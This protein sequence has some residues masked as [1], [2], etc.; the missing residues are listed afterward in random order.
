MSTQIFD[1]VELTTGIVFPKASGLGIKI[2]PFGPAAF[3][4]RDLTGQINPHVGGGATPPVSTLV[5]GTGTHVRAYAFPTNAVIDDITFHMPHDYVPGTDMYLHLHWT[6]AGTAIS[7][8]LV[9][10]WY[11]TY[12]KGYNQASQT[13][14]AE[15]NV[16]L[17][18]PTANV[19]AFPKYG[20]FINEFQITNVGGDA[21]HID[22][23]TLEVDGLIKVGAIATTI[24][25]ISGSP[26]GSANNPFFLM[27][28][29]HYQSAGLM[30]TKNKN[31]PFYT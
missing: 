31:F 3:G 2:D 18:I 26:G 12:C 15:K 7:G 9:V 10:D 4:F 29:L 1:S 24:P 20:H 27:V 23:T 17:T 5:R 6:H 13:F 22:N 8:N 14:F 25:S 11:L 30:T 19:T 21:T 28:D 16:T